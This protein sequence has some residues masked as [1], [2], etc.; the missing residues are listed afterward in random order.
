M[1]CMKHMA[2]QRCHIAQWQDRLKLS[3]KAEITFRTTSL[4]DDPTWRT[5]Q[6]A[7]WFPDGCIWP[8]DCAWVN[9][10]ILSMSQNCAPH[11]ARHSGLPQTCS[12]L[13]TQLNFRGVT[14]APLCSR[15][16]LVGPLPKG[17]WRLPWTYR[18]YGKNLVS[19]IRT[20]LK[21]PI[22]KI[23]SIPVLLF[24]RECSIHNVLWR[25]CSLW[26]MT[27]WGNTVPRCTSKAD[28]QTVNAAYY[29]TFLQ[30]HS[31]TALRRKRQVMVKNPIIFHNT[32][33]NH[34]TA[35]VTDILCRWQWEILE[36]PP[37]SSDMNTM[38]SPKW[39]NHWEGSGTT[40]KMNLSEL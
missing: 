17:R 3:G 31:R 25:W 14:M 19:L 15:T 36:N 28:W 7:S 1:D 35:A 38:S 40:Q 39:K 4:L 30:H 34:T 10:G 23:G 32:E 11:S 13:D 26:R 37:Y 8:M 18:R 27:L 29:C 16:G 24:Q 2:M 22:K 12:P 21:T 33:R 6:L 9:S 5:T 20:K